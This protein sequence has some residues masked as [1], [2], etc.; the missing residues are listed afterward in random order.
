MELSV[1]A[2]GLVSIGE[3]TSWPFDGF[4]AAVEAG[5]IVAHVEDGTRRCDLRIVDGT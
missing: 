1:Y 3:G 4:A 5:D 2:D